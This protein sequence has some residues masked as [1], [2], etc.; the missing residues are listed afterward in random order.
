MYLLLV[1]YNLIN[2]EDLQVMLD[3]APDGTD[4]VNCNSL[5]TLLNVTEKLSPDI[6][7]VDFELVKAEINGLFDNLRDKSRQSHVMALIEPE[8][9]EYLYKAIEG[10]SVDDFMVKPINKEDFFARIKI[11][12]RKRHETAAP[13]AFD[14]E[15]S[16]QS[17]LFFIDRAGDEDPGKAA[18][19]VSELIFEDLDRE[20]EEE[21]FADEYPTDGLQTA[22]ETRL[23]DEPSFEPAGTAGEEEVTEYDLAADYNLELFEEDTP[24]EPSA[25]QAQQE[26]ADGAPYSTSDTEQ[27]QKEPDE[28]QEQQKPDEQ[29]EQAEQD[30]A[31]SPALDPSSALGASAGFETYSELEPDAELGPSSEINL[32]PAG[33]FEPAGEGE[34]EA[35]ADFDFSTATEED[36]ALS[37]A[38]DQYRSGSSFSDEGD[39]EFTFER[40][41]GDLEQTGPDLLPAGA[42]MDQGE[43]TQEYTGF[44][45]EPGE[46]DL[47]EAGTDLEESRPEFEQAKPDLDQDASEFAQF[48]Q[49]WADQEEPAATK[50]STGEEF[51][52]SQKEFEQPAGQF[53]TEADPYEER[54]IESRE[55]FPVINAGERTTVSSEEIDSLF[56]DDVFEDDVKSAAGGPRYAGPAAP[57]G[58][59]DSAPPSTDDMFGPAHASQ[60]TPQTQSFGAPPSDYGDDAFGARQAEPAH[61]PFGAGPQAPPTDHFGAPSSD[62]YGDTS[63]DPAPPADPSYGAAPTAPPGDPSFGAPPKASSPDAP[64]FGAGPTAGPGGG[65]GEAPPAPG[66]DTF[67]AA[68]PRQQD[69]MFGAPPTEQRRTTRGDAVSAFED[70]FSATPGAATPGVATPGVATPGAA[71]QSDQY[72]NDILDEPAT[73]RQAA[74]PYQAEQPSPSWT[75]SSYE[76]PAYEQPAYG[77]PA[78]GQPGQD[79]FGAPPSDRPTVQRE[80]PFPGRSADEYLYGRGPGAQDEGYNQSMLDEF[81]REG[82]RPEKVSKPKKKS[83]GGGFSTFM[84]VLGNVVFIFLLLVMATLSFF[85]IQSRITGGVPEVAGYQMYIVLSGSMSPEFDTGALAFVREIEPFEIQ[86]GDIITYRS[87]A[88]SDSLTTHRV[89][90]VVLDDGLKFVTRGDANNVNDPNPVLAEN[91]VGHVTGSVPYV[92]YV[93]NFVQTRQG[94]ILLIFVPGVLIIV[95]E[96]GKIMKY[97]TQGEGKKEKRGRRKVRYAEESWE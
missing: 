70:T 63:F 6:I 46:P 13:S 93:L 9:Y 26:E 38:A 24:V 43:F 83:S 97:L 71:G 89:V 84:S 44:D 51:A 69:D 40:A 32:E 68:V 59:Y 54:I 3:Q 8:H 36:D 53:S 85:L 72:F 79:P 33:E 16:E 30:L 64:S 81:T 52:A 50:A 25:P 92:G 2:N 94:L 10:G 77:Q 27:E 61:D 91:V 7:I 96:L 39:E 48:D 37:P 22:E 12:M 23:V 95:F 73:Q 1:D 58:R 62:Y 67:G 78:Y 11:A 65:F 28:Q 80:S 86:V 34:F 57:P 82:E 4:I 87:R 47:E 20:V 55:L 76:Q 42:E 66:G 29:Q 49:Q 41:G 19:D 35:V 5:E 75:P 90:E 56:K 18:D 15:K 60:A 88:D 14:G 21:S 17:E 31:P 74:A 45:L